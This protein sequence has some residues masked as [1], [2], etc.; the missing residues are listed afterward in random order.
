MK[1]EAINI[2]IRTCT[3]NNRQEKTTVP[4]VLNNFI[5]YSLW[6]ISNN[7]LVNLNL[8]DLSYVVNIIYS[9]MNK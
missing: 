6:S 8:S 4:T 5:T 3:I 1:R 7:V 9:I 2:N